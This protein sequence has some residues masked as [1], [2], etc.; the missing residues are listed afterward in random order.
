[1]M[2]WATCLSILC[3]DGSLIFVSDPCCR[4]A[5]ASN[6]IDTIEKL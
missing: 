5:E 1:M 2:L 3:F 4:A 6:D